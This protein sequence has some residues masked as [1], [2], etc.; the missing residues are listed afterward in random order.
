[1][2]L[3]GH[4]VREDSDS[5][6]HVKFSFFDKMRQNITMVVP[7]LNSVSVIPQD[8]YQRPTGHARDA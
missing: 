5:P 2:N 1:M 7:T 4:V 6:E 8:R 3:H